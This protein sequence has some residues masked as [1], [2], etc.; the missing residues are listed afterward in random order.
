[1]VA[2]YQD[3]RVRYY[4]DGQFFQELPLGDNTGDPDTP[5]ILGIKDGNKARQIFNMYTRLDMKR[6]TE[7]LFAHLITENRPAGS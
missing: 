6:E 4:I 7:L 1:M 5:R 3:R 2:V